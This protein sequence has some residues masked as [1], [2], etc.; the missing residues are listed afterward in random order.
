MY[1]TKLT[2][3]NVR[4][5]KGEHSISL[6]REV[7][8]D[9]ADW[10][11][12]A[13]WTVLTGRNGSGKTTALRAIVMGLLGDRLPSSYVL[14]LDWQ[15]K[16]QI[17]S[18]VQITLQH[19]SADHGRNTVGETNVIQ[20][21]VY[22]EEG[23]GLGSHHSESKLDSYDSEGKRVGPWRIDPKGFFLAA[24]GA[25]RRL[26]SPGEEIGDPL[27]VD[28]FNRVITL[29]D[30]SATLTESIRW[31]RYHHLLRLEKQEASDT[32]IQH[33]IRLLADGLLPDNNRVEEVNY[34]GLLITRDGV[35]LPI[36][37]ISDGYRAVV[38][39]VVDLIRQL[40]GAFDDLRF[41][42]RDGRWVCELPGV[43][44]IDEVD[45]HLH[46]EWQRRIGFWL[47]AHFPRIQ[48]IVTSH[49]PF[50]CQAAS[51]KGLIRL[52]GPGEDR[53]IEH[54]P[55]HIYNGVV[56][57]GIDEAVMSELFGLD[58]PRSDR[59]EALRDHVAALEIKVLKKTASEAELEE[60]KAKKAL[61]PDDMDELADRSVRRLLHSRD[62]Q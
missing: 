30:E 29:F 58:S 20:Q 35:K 18:S 38:S 28:R 49:S 37:Q 1:L 48:F 6:S 34:K 54:V 47:T 14:P 62:A 42:E 61:L 53:R 32:L 8:S 13:G 4:C 3:Q 36:Q 23:V 31:L 17:R 21:W 50:I 59:A 39:L 11:N 55:E 26:G 40:S 9:P 44:L 27:P 33:T 57:G 46:V 41:V 15:T 19:D 24:Y 43:V 2:L 7:S 51:P 56:N 22:S 60:Y 16:K 10:R 45:A 12:Y 5:F 52:P 25:K